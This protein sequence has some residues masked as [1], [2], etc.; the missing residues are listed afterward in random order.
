[1]RILAIRG[2]NL[3]SL[4][5][6][7]AIELEQPPLDR[8]G[9]FA[10]TGPT[11]AGK[12]TLLDAICLALFDEIPRLP[13]SQGVAVGRAGEPDEHRLKSTDVCSILRRDSSDGFA[14]VDFIGS[15]GRRYRARWEV[16]RTRAGGRLRRQELSLRDLASGQR[17]GCTKTEVLDLIAERLGLNFAQF[18][19]SVLLPQGDFAAFLKVDAK[20]RSELLERITGTE[21]YGELSQAAHQRA[22]AEKKRLEELEQRLGATPLLDGAERRALEQR[23]SAEQRKYQQAEQARQAAQHVLKWHQDLAELERWESQAV[24]DLEA[25]RRD[26]QAAEPRRREWLAAQQAQPLRCL[27]DEYDRAVGECEQARQ[28]LEQARATADQAEAKLAQARQDRQIREAAWQQASAGLESARPALQ[29]ARILD[30]QLRELC[31][32]HARL[33]RDAESTA[34]RAKEA[35]QYLDKLTAE[36]R[37]V[38]EQHAAIGHW[39]ADNAHLNELAR[40]WERWDNAFGSFVRTADEAEGIRRTLQTLD[41]RSADL[42]QRLAQA[43]EPSSAARQAVADA[44]QSL[45]ALEK[46]AAGL[47]SLDVLRRQRAG[48]EERRDRL[49]ALQALTREAGVKNQ[50]LARVQAGLQEL[51]QQAENTGREAEETARTLERQEAALRE[52][53]NAWQRALIA[54][55][56]DVQSLR[57]WLQDG[58][59][60]PVCGATEHPWAQDASP[61]AYWLQEQQQRVDMLKHQVQALTAAYAGQTA[62]Q[63]QARQRYADWQEQAQILAEELTRLRRRWA[64]RPAEERLTDDPA[65][66]E[67]TEILAQRLADVETELA[68][69]GEA[70]CQALEIQE[71]MAKLRRD[72]DRHRERSDALQQERA[73]WQHALQKLATEQ[74]AQQA[75]LATQERTLQDLRD[76]LAPPLAGLADWQQTL[77]DDPRALHARCERQALDW[78][79]RQQTGE[80]LARRLEEVGLALK[81]AEVQARA[82]RELAEASAAALSDRQQKLQTLQQQRQHLLNGRP[83]DRVERELTQAE[84]TAREALEQAGRALDLANSAHLTARTKADHCN[85]TLAARQTARDAA[86]R[87]LDR[88]LSEQGLELST[89]R[90]RLQHQAAWLET[91]RTELDALRT[92]YERIQERLQERHANRAKHQARPPSQ[93]HA[94][95]EL[96]S[97]KAEHDSQEAHRIW[98]E[99]S[100]RLR[101][102]EELRAQALRLREDS[103]SQRQRWELWE[104]LRE[105]IGSHDGSVF[106]SYAQ[107]LTLDILLAHANRHLEDL[108]RRYRLERVPGSDMELQVIDREMGDEVRSVHSLSGGESFLVSLALAL[109]LASLSSQRTRVESLFIDEGFGSLDSDTLEVALASLDALQSQGRKVGVISHLPAMVERIGVQVRVEVKGGGRSAIQVVDGGGWAE[110]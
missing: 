70:E 74:A 46:S 18:R 81:E 24:A 64:E 83:A 14:E 47:A 66:E 56:E 21:I 77:T 85:D 68:G 73:D 104:S 96:Q 58:E 19:R 55:K 17:L 98:V 76:Q 32:Q 94:E 102:D 82:A 16:R 49:R 10:I 50:A 54:R 34:T 80:A 108:A 103:E 67:L 13:K 15:D 97:T 59:P 106:R 75:T 93:S 30:R 95:A 63:A 37:D 11:G 31:E 109:G 36:R 42:K 88:V 2:K 44:R 107:S 38:R 53:E 29:E 101:Q 45:R 52:A 48:L 99:I 84:K 105:L 23:C 26:W 25:A 7:F 28:G 39:L 35:G 90:R 65:A 91:E 43:D 79:Q 27:M 86:R 40:Q 110:G 9:L 33:Q 6:R 61:L 12:S 71:G 20:A 4:E 8:A 89:L 72:L 60:C 69:I 51:R 22:M 41:G 1:M 78:R 62:S 92:H 100:A 87:H 3:A 5:G 57:A